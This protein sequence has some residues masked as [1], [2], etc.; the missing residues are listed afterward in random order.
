[1]YFYFEIYN[2]KKGSI[3]QVNE[4]VIQ[5]TVK[6][7]ILKQEL[8]TLFSICQRSLDFPSNTVQLTA[9]LCLIDGT[10]YLVMDK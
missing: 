9:Y 1:M 2:V 7:I 4:K 5:N 10:T 8:R 3:I 6:I